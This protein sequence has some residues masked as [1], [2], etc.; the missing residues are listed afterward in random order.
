MSRLLST[1]EDCRLRIKAN[2]YPQEALVAVNLHAPACLAEAS[3]VAANRSF[4]IHDPAMP[5]DWLA[6]PA[7]VR[8]IG[9]QSTP[10]LYILWADI[11]YNWYVR[12][13]AHHTSTERLGSTSSPRQPGLQ[14]QI[15]VDLLKSPDRLLTFCTLLSR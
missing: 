4:D 1:L 9:D 8:H 7:R 3:R 13:D 2:E 6:H 14:R 10:R 11:R 15:S 12:T 5:S